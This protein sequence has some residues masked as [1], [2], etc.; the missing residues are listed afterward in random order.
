MNGLYNAEPR[1]EHDDDKYRQC[2]DNRNHKNKW[3]E[4]MW[5]RMHEIL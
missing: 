5:F 3:V 4:K 1:I 2:F